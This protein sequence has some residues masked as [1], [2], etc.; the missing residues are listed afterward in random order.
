MAPVSLG[1]R[2]W[3]HGSCH[4][5]EAVVEG[6]KEGIV[7]DRIDLLCISH[8]DRDHV[9]GLSYLLPG[10]TI[11]TLVLPNVSS[12]ERLVLGA[13]APTRGG[14]PDG[15][16]L[17]FLGDP[18]GFILD[19][20]EAVERVI[21]VGGDP[22]DDL[23]GGG[24]LPVGEPPEGAAKE[25][26]EWNLKPRSFDEAEQNGFWSRQAKSV[27]ATHGAPFLHTLSSFE[28]IAFT[29]TSRAQWEFCFFHKP[30]PDEVLRRLR[31]ELNELIDLWRRQEG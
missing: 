13:G 19:R 25:Q 6:Y 15:E 16:Y 9:S 24:D 21:L 7:D 23:G 3:I 28:A 10:L 1:F 27:A 11:G 8:F 20:A 17:D 22:P 2:L 18:V 26:G 14:D 4:A 30:L 12:I 29:D 31:R 5:L